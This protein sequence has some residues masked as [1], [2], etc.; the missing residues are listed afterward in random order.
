LRGCVRW[1]RDFATVP[2][3]RHEHALVAAPAE[4]IFK[5]LFDPVMGT[6]AARISIQDAFSRFHI[7]HIGMSSFE[8][9][10]IL[11]L[12]DERG[13]ERCLWRQTGMPGIEDCRLWRGEMENVAIQFCDSF[14]QEVMAS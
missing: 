2:R 13:G 4:E 6:S 9:F 7:S 10:D 1:L 11:L 3:D 5:R 14:E 12:Y 8:H